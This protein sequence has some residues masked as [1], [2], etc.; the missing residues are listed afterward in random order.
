[1][2][3][4]T[5]FIHGNIED[6]KAVSCLSINLFQQVNIPFYPSDQLRFSGL[7][8]TQLHKSADTVSVAIKNIV[9]GHGASKFVILSITTIVLQ[10]RVSIDQALSSW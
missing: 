5:I 8:Q 9:V 1:M 7:S 2:Q 3:I 10:P 6:S 4:I